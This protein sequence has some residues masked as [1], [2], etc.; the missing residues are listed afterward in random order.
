[1]KSIVS[2]IA[3]II[4][5]YKEEDALDIAQKIKPVI[6]DYANLLLTQHRTQLLARVETAYVDDYGKKM[7]IL[8]E[9]NIHLALE[10]ILKRGE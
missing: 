5:E 6:Q 9:E 7:N 3:N 2:K 4:A 8:T 1:M 10:E